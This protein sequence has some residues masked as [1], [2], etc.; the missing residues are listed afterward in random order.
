MMM[1]S[2]VHKWDSEHWNEL[3]TFHRE[4][5]EV[6]FESSLSAE[7]MFCSLNYS[8]PY[9][10]IFC[11]IKSWKKPWLLWVLCESDTLRH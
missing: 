4:E 1:V 8:L 3:L 11:Q 10:D 9:G 5:S 7:P 2:Q 6:G